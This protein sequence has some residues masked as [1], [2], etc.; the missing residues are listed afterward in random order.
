[1]YT[2][3][4]D[5]VIYIPEPLN[6]YL[7]KRSQELGISRSRLVQNLIQREMKNEQR[8]EAQKRR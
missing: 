3:G 8:R 2:E 7:T 5:R 4:M 6:V 1:M